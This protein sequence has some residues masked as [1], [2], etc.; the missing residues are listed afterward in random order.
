MADLPL[1]LH[2][3]TVKI[4]QE[5]HYEYPNRLSLLNVVARHPKLGELAKMRG[6]IVGRRPQFKTHGDFLQM[7]DDESEESL[8]FSEGLF[9]THSNVH[10]WLID[11]GYKSGSGC[12]GKEL[13]EGQIV[14]FED[15]TVEEQASLFIY[16]LALSAI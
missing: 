6:I 2:E 16:L 15:L 3:C 14:H 1:N 4:T 11:G 7:M 5:A 9:D 12:W 13:N 8:H 10:P